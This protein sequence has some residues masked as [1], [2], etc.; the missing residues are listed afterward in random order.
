MIIFQPEDHTY[1]WRKPDFSTELVPSVSELIDSAGFRD[2]GGV[3]PHVLE[4]ARL[5]G[6]QVDAVIMKH[7]QG[8][9]YNLQEDI[10]DYDKG[11]KMFDAWLAFRNKYPFKVI[12]LQTPVHHP[13]EDPNQIPRYAGTPDIIIEHDGVQRVLEIKCTSRVM[14]AHGV[15]TW[16]YHLA[17]WH[18]PEEGKHGYPWLVRLGKDGKFFLWETKDAQLLNYQALAVMMRYQY[19]QSIPNKDKKGLQPYKEKR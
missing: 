8:K 2:Y 5:R 19:W 14:E 16:L 6:E 3:D 1:L 13:I 12:E 9:P 18:A 11:S 17:K 7:E 4:R 10:F 15:Q